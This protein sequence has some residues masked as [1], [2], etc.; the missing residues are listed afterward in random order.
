MTYQPREVTMESDAF[1]LLRQVPPFSGLD[2]PLL[3]ALAQ[4]L[5][6][7]F[8]RLGTMIFR[9]DQP[10]DALHIVETGH[11]RLFLPSEEGEEISIDV[12]G[13][14]DVFGEMAL[15][16]GQP[17]SASAETLEDTITHRLGREDFRHQLLET[18]HL[19]FPL[20]E[21]LS[22]RVRNTTGY[23]ESLA[24][25]DL[26]ARLARVLL[27]LAE[28][29]G[30]QGGEGIQIDFDLSE[31]EL[32]AMVGVSRERV[33][34]GMAAFRA[35]K[36]V[37]LR[38]K[39]LVLLNPER[40]RQLLTGKEKRTQLL[41]PRRV[42]TD[43]LQLGRIIVSATHPDAG[44]IE[45]AVRDFS[46][47]DLTLILPRSSPPSGGIRTGDPL[48]RLVVSCSDGIVYEGAAIVLGASEEGQ[49]VAAHVELDAGG[50][51]LPRLYEWS[52]RRR[53]AQRWQG[54][55]KKASHAD[56][57]LE[58]KAWVA[59]LRA[60]LEETRDFLGSEERTLETQDL[61]VRQEA[62]Q[63]YVA[64]AVPELVERMNVALIELT[65]LVGDLS[66]EHHAACRAYFRAHALPLLQHSP[67]LR[68]SFERPLGYA[69]DYEMMNMLYR[70]PAEGE[71]L[72]G[73]VLNCYA[74]QETG[75]RAVRNRMTYFADRIRE[76]VQSETAERVRVANIGSGPARELAV[77]LETS[78]ELG[79]RLD[80][81]LIDQE[82]RALAYCERTLGPLAVRT[83]AR[84]QLIREP[85]RW[86]AGGQRLSHTSAN[87]S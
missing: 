48:T 26:H 39:R 21:L 83:G 29:D 73:R 10:G 63:Q 3:G 59:D 68:R 82:E 85:I 22:G 51:D 56:V 65:A 58:F 9:K 38:G 87:G 15:L 81:A 46:L 77:L 61:V 43:T 86:L 55:N 4:R 25:L 66:D 20:L 12:V 84:I 69:G 14:K 16:D 31:T 5:E 70:D 76:V 33:E 18:P 17:R 40:L 32:A 36:L 75:A 1:E 23:I 52:A 74:A 71:A 44:R 62:L 2:A 35:Q 27:D 37:A 78:P 50:L 11:V 64:E 28:R 72:F 24:F 34:R 47:H 19:A 80:V 30:A 42:R 67:L 7:R 49:D 13:R 60:Y 6:R 41:R 8:F 45:A 57:T 79:P 53:F 54:F